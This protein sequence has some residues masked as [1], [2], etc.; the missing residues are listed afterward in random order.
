MGGVN[1]WA[2]WGGV[3]GPDSLGS[4]QNLADCTQA[5]RQRAILHTQ[6]CSSHIVKTHSLSVSDTK[7]PCLADFERSL[8][9]YL[10]QKWGQPKFLFLRSLQNL[11]PGAQIE[12]LQMFSMHEPPRRSLAVAT[13][14]GTPQE[15]PPFC[16]EEAALGPCQACLYMPEHPGVLCRVGSVLSRP[17]LDLLFPLRSQ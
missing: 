13:G 3:G 11:P 15:A 14:A 9:I 4:S 10:L 12:R 8:E 7:Q 17:T 16:A 1:G 5:L 2:L 6:A